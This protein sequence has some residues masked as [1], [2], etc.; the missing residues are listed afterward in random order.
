MNSV[1]ASQSIQPETISARLDARLLPELRRF[2]G[3]WNATLKEL[4]QNAHR[5]GATRVEIKLEGKRLTIQDNGCGLEHPGVLLSAGQTQW[6]EGAVIEPAG[7]GVFSLIDPDLASSVVFASHG[8]RLHLE[9]EAVLAGLASPI[10]T[11]AFQAGMNL[12][13]ELHKAPE[14]LEEA[15]EEARGFYPFDLFLN[16]KP[17]L[18]P[19]LPK[20]LELET[21][22]GLV[23][24]EHTHRSYDRSVIGIWEFQPISGKGLLEVLL[25][26][27]DQ[28]RHP[29]LADDCRL[30]ASSRAQLRQSGT[31][32]T[33]TCFSFSQCAD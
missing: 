23:T 26:I 21:E 30:L 1:L 24:W 17:I 18:P 4:L 12:E 19:T 25:K 6:D 28:C 27:S 20:H 3:G 13:V 32:L 2:F 11:V 16:G 22:V 5:A 10:Q 8:W 9:P 33:K 29:K 15:L 7:L 31:S 14:K